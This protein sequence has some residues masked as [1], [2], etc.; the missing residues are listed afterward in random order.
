MQPLGLAVG[1]A[2]LAGGLEPLE[3]AG[4]V[5]ALGAGPAGHLGQLPIGGV[6][7]GV[8]N[9]A[10]LHAGKRLVD[11]RLPHRHRVQD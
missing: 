7:D 6:H 2:A 1:A 10:L 8:T 3:Q 11:V 9:E 5:E 4:R